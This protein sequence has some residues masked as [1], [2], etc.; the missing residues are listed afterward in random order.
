MHLRPVQDESALENIL[1]PGVLWYSQ[2]WG[3][4][5]AGGRRRVSLLEEERRKGETNPL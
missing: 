5:Q 1:G 3:R 4:G 2:W